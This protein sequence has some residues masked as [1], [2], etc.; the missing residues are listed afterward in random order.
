MKATQ[1]EQRLARYFFPANVVISFGIL[2]VVSAGGWDVTNHLL[3]KPE[4]FFSAPHAMLYSGVVITLS[5][6]ILLFLSW[7]QQ[8]SNFK[9]HFKFPVKMA[10]I[11]IFILVS[12]GPSDFVWHSNFGL[13]G[14]LSPPHQLLLLGMFLCCISSMVSIVRLY[15]LGKKPSFLSEAFVMLSMLPVWM[16]SS[17]FVYSYSL[18]FS[19]TDYFDFNPEI[20][21]AATLA[22][23]AL[24]FLNSSIL[25]MTSKIT[26]HKFGMLSG[27]GILL[28]VINAANSII[29]NQ[30]LFDTLPFYFLSIIPYV[31]ADAL[32]AF[33]KNK[34]SIIVAGAIL[35]SIMYFVYY[36]LITHIYNE[37]VF[38]RIVSGSVTFFVYFEQLPIVFPIIIVPCLIMGILGAK[39]SYKIFN[40]IL[41]YD[42]LTNTVAKK[43]D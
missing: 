25:I 16:V 23:V 39:F 31:S 24:P 4:T 17:G 41:P 21:F 9:K 29:P 34:K 19:K 20:Y 26:N 22:T 40:L 27:A 32:I 37:V 8:K 38:D 3:N 11:G 7:N 14:L 1:T 18:P 30:F 42:L 6:T 10:I 2:T 12:A 35:G 36:P 33:Y 5:G 15:K 28:L 13:D 43:S